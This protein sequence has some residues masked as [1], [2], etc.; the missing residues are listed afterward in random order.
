MQFGEIAYWVETPS[1]ER[2]SRMPFWISPWS[3]SM[4]SEVSAAVARAMAN[5]PPSSIGER[6]VPDG[7][8]SGLRQ[9]AAVRR[10]TSPG[11]ADEGCKDSCDLHDVAGNHSIEPPLP[12]RQRLE[13]FNLLLCQCFTTFIMND[14]A[15]SFVNPLCYSNNE[16]LPPTYQ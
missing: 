5:K 16:D 13:V 12:P 7:S 9:T 14:A 2:M 8:S 4:R 3:L 15:I 11:N 1:L 6:A 10:A